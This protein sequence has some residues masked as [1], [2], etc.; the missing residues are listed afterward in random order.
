MKKKTACL[1]KE[2]KI[3]EVYLVQKML[4]YILTL[5]QTS[6][7]GKFPGTPKI[8][9]LKYTSCGLRKRELKQSCT[10]G[11]YYTTWPYR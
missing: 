8:K 5:L 3:L 4:T 10:K 7:S 2:A 9:R 1:T 6:L 11:E